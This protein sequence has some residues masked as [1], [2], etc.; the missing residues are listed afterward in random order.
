[1][2]N[3]KLIPFLILFFLFVTFFQPL[4]ALGEDKPQYKVKVFTKRDGDFIDFYAEN[5]ETYDITISIDFTQFDN[6]QA[7]VE[8]PY[9]ETIPA[10][11]QMKVFTI[12]V[13]D[14]S[15]RW[16]YKSAY[17]FITG[18]LYAQHDN[19]TVYSLPYPS[20]VKHKVTQGFNGSFS[21][22]G[23][24]Q[25]A[26][27]WA[28]KEGS[29][30][31]AARDGVVVGVRDYFSEGAPDESYRSKA[32][33]VIIKHIDGTYAEYLH[34]MEGGAQV[35]VGQDVKAGDVIALSGNTGY[36]SGPHLHFSVYKTID[37]KTRETF[38]IQF[39]TKEFGTVT[40]E[41]GYFYTTP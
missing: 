34:I 38:P 19:T 2:F 5:G 18:S 28:M 16:Q 15:E 36:S 13:V 8:L 11:E 17:F 3:K 22:S 14:K 26:I 1:M 39:N 20:G 4:T 40:L 10:G 25:Y 29:K 41:R 32:N 35:Y 21:H 24:D 27:D 23:N 33:F 9:T 7:D 30:I 31:C 12:Q 37:G 6:L